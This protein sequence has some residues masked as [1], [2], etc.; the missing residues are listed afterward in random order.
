MK[1]IGYV[2]NF[3]DN[4]KPLLKELKNHHHV[5]TFYNDEI[6]VSNIEEKLPTHS[7]ILWR[8]LSP[9]GSKQDRIMEEL[10]EKY[11]IINTHEAHM[12]AGDK[13]A[14]EQTLNKYKIP[15]IPTWECAAGVNIPT[16]HIVKPR[17]GM[18][19]EN[20]LYG[21]NTIE[22]LNEP[23]TRKAL[24]D[25]ASKWIMQPYIAESSKWLRI[26][27]I[28][29]EPVISYRRVPPPGRNIANVNQGA[30]KEYVT[31]PK[32]AIELAVTAARKT[33]LTIAGVDITHKPHMIVE[34]N[35][36][37]AIP[38]KALDDVAKILTKKLSNN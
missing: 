4:F 9:Y 12:L 16:N 34:L 7:T 6:T 24:S 27:V 32:D 25:G 8:A 3:H 18:K 2:T 13:L 37:P 31:P 21:E 5:E 26:L 22:P 38:D 33:G 14:T 36:V 11:T 17:Y 30:T 10:S 23:V 29:G 15:A 35:S 28:N 1:T 20:I 19:G